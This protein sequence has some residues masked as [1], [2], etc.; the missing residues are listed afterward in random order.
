MSKEARDPA[1]GG[2]ARCGKQAGAVDRAEAV[3]RVQARG[4]KEEITPATRLV[5]LTLLGRVVRQLCAAGVQKI[6]LRTGRDGPPKHD[7][8]TAPQD[9]DEAMRRVRREFPPSVGMVT[10]SAPDIVID[11]CNLYDVEA[12]EA[13]LAQ[14]AHETCGRFEKENPVEVKPRLVLNRAADLPRARKLIWGQA[15][16][17][18][19]HD[20]LVAY[21]V[22]RPLGRLLSRLLVSTSVTPNAVTLASLGI[23]LI[24]AGLAAQGGRWFLTLGAFLYWFGMV[25]DCVDGDLARV[26]LEGSRL[27]QWLDTVADDISTAAITLGFGLGLARQTGALF[28][29]WAG[30]IGF[31]AITVSAAYVYRGLLKYRLPIDTARYPWFF[32]G[33]QGLVAQENEHGGGLSVVT[34]LIR[35]DFS[36]AALTVLA[37]FG[38]AWLAF[39]ILFVGACATALLAGIDAIVKAPEKPWGGAGEKPA[40][41]SGRPCSSPSAGQDRAGKPPETKHN[42]NGQ[43]VGSQQ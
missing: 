22:G 17:S 6:D 32:L 28:Y 37:A 41:C 43:T 18:V 35:R 23:G 40:K 5:G 33:R 29:A 7:G 2:K 4:W 19:A 1:V 27:G 11:G 31:A 21:Y 39:D 30:P 15:G 3:A 13:A 12:I 16:K 42:T 14:A 26:R 36:S 24:G 20:G 34:F 9:D 25:I 38:L 8:P 10:T